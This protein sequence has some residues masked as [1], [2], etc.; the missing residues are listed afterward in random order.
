[1]KWSSNKIRLYVLS[2]NDP[3]FMGIWKGHHWLCYIEVGIYSQFS[4][5][6]NVSTSEFIECHNEAHAQQSLISQIAKSGRE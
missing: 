4:V 3:A 2:G 6:L 1:M 5:S